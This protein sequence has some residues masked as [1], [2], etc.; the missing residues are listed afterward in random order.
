VSLRSA[1]SVGHR[2]R[3]AS[4]PDVGRAVIVEPRLLEAEGLRGILE[5]EGFASVAVATAGPEALQIVVRLR[6]TIVLVGMAM[7]GAIELGRRILE[8]APGTK[9]VGLASCAEPRKARRAIRVGFHGFLLK[10]SSARQFVCSIQAVLA[11]QIVLPPELCWAAVE[12]APPAGDGE[13]PERLSA[14]ELDV[15]HLLSQGA[16]SGTI[17][18]RLWISRNTVRSHVQNIL[19]K[20]EVHSR[21]EAVAFAATHGLIEPDGP[22]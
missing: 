8:E 2:H 17:A 10:L 4:V 18:S 20:L 19:A 7:P 11:G 9:M 12:P 21:L 3:S 15:L 14:R 6:P 13:A 1:T 22:A 5:E 16:D